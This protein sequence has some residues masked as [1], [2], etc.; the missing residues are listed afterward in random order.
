M[1]LRTLDKQV[2][3]S[4]TRAFQHG[5]ENC[6]QH[7][8]DSRCAKVLSFC[9]DLCFL[10]HLLELRCSWKD[11]TVSELATRCHLSPTLFASGATVTTLDTVLADNMQFQ[12][13]CHTLLQHRLQVKKN[14]LVSLK[15]LVTWNI[16]GGAVHRLQEGNKFRI[17]RRLSNTGIVCLQETRWTEVG[18]T[19]LQQRLTGTHVLHSPANITQDG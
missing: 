2:L 12:S 10:P 15:R 13:L 5:V 17:I 16:G 3:R 11:V 19:A 4:L 8:F 14:L 18:A 7:L 9:R 6:Y 1:T